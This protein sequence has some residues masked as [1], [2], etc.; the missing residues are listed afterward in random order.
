[1]N[2]KVKQKYYYFFLTLSNNLSNLNL[3]I[4]TIYICV[5]NTVC[6]HC[7]TWVCV[8][9]PAVASTWTGVFH[10]GSEACWDL[11]SLVTWYSGCRLPSLPVFRPC[12]SPFPLLP[13]LAAP[14]VRPGGCRNV[15]FGR[16]QLGGGLR[17]GSA[18]DKKYRKRVNSSFIRVLLWAN[19]HQAQRAIGLF[20]ERPC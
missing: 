16:L 18:A 11:R 14:C 9:L 10:L 4:A 8:R 15:S 2:L 19:K 7:P 13:P 6:V 12:L 17:S 3:M 20:P 5:V 1:M